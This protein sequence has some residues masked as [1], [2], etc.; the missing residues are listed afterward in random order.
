MKWKCLLGF[1]NWVKRIHP[2][3]GLMLYGQK[4]CLDCGD[5]AIGYTPKNPASRWSIY[6]RKDK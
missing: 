2:E 1:H 3:S 4:V 6:G 5:Q